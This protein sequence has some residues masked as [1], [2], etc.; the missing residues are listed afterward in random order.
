MEDMS[1]KYENMLSED[2]NLDEIKESFLEKVLECAS[3]DLAS[4]YENQSVGIA[5]SEN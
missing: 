4:R 1:N 2:I 3:T 5:V